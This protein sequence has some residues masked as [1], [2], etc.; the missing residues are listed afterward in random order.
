MFVYR[1]FNDI[2]SALDHD[3]WEALNGRNLIQNCL[4]RI[5]I[6]GQFERLPAIRL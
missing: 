5:F 1:L 2:R 3:L 4:E 6:V